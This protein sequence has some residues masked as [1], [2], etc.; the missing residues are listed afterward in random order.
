M[1]ILSTI[2]CGLVSGLIAR[3]LIPGK[4]PPRGLIMTAVL[5]VGG[6]MLAAYVGQSMG[7]YAVGEK[8]GLLGAVVGSIVVVLAYGLLTKGRK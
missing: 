4:T 3:F 7:L 8:A 1:G 5:G 2:L 6:A